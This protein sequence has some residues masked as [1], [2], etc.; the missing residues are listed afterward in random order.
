MY[1][2]L[3]H[4]YDL[5]WNKVIDVIEEWCHGLGSPIALQRK[6]HG[7]LVREK[8]PHVQD[9]NEFLSDEKVCIARVHL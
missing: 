8:L 3:T 7:L 2:V 1:I 9:P 6:E 4:L 5:E